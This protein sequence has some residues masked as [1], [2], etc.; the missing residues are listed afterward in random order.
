VTTNAFGFATKHQSL[1]SNLKDLRK[2]CVGLM[3]D[4]CKR[5]EVASEVVT[6]VK[7]IKTK[8]L[9]MNS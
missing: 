1:D 8:T 3:K 7:G 2:L 9:I 6:I 5:V 4:L